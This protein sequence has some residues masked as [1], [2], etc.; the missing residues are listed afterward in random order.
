ML[1]QL[2]YTPREPRLYNGS[3]PVRHLFR[4]A[5]SRMALSASALTL[6]SSHVR[7]GQMFLV[8]LGVPVVAAAAMGEPR[9]ALLGGVAA[10]VLSFADNERPLPGRL[11]FLL[12]S[13]GS[14]VLCGLAG[15]ALHGV[16]HV[17]W[18]V[19]VAIV[20]GVGLAARGGREPL[21]A[22]RDGAM[23]FSTMAAV[24]AVN[25][26][27]LWFLA[28]MLAVIVLT[29]TLDAAI[30][31]PLPQLAAGQPLRRPADRAGWLRFALAYAAA[32]AAALWIGLTLDPE[33]AVW[34]STTT[35]LVMQPDAQA[36][37]RR[38]FERI[39]G[40]FVGVIL[41]WAIAAAI[42][43]KTLVCA[44]AVI[45]V[46]FIPHHVGQRYWLHTALVALFILL[47]YDFSLPT[48]HDLDQVLVERLKDM[49]MGCAI[50]VVGTTAAFLRPGEP[51]RPG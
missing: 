22:S 10:L 30:Y 7:R 25:L 35:L 40:T 31:G 48:I 4:N 49:L 47:L 3:N 26:A 34:V 44:A 38:I 39:L 43:D 21:I 32:S 6:R 8:N 50:A 28:G 42:G 1:Y 20:F 12:T 29:R 23:A 45:T 41:A 46:P 19:Y 16:P 33:R 9:L 17:F 18:P 36:S 2:S 15:F 27:D 24:P 37:H 14:M 11:R 5:M 51:E 13:A